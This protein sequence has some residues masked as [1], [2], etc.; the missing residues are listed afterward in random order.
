MGPQ[1]LLPLGGA[2]TTQ[3]ICFLNSG[4][5]QCVQTEPVCFG[6][7]INHEGVPEPSEDTEP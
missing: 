2:H 7:E 5:V 6:G 4:S 1:Q 3:E